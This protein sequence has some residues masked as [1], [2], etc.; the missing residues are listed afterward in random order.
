MS[1]L[2]AELA[3]LAPGASKKIIDGIVAN[4]NFLDEAG[5]TTPLR[6]RHFFARVCVETYGLKRLD[7]NL[8]Y[9]AA[10]LT[11][12]WPKRFPTLASAKPYANNPRKLANK[13]YGGRLG[14]SA[15]NDDGYDH[16]GSGLLQNTGKVN[17]QLVQDETG[18]PV[19]ENPDLLRKFPTALQAATLYWTKHNINKFADKD[20]EVGVCHAVNGGENGLAEQRAYLHTARKVWP[21]GSRPAPAK[22][23]V[24]PI[25]PAKETVQRVQQQL[26]DLNYNPG[27]KDPVKGWDGIPGKLTN[28]AILSFKNDHGLPVNT[29]IDEAFL[30]ALASAPPR[31]MA[32]A[33]ANATGSQV[34]AKVPE[35]NVH[36]WTRLGAYIGLGSTT[37]AG[38]TDYIAPS[39]GYLQTIKDF[40]GDV[41]PWVWFLGVIALCF[42][43]GIAAQYGLNKTKQAFNSGDRR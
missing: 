36:W 22:P 10:R 3:R 4:A 9:S 5:I 42:I 21:E 15:K 40:V 28:G 32:P 17:F 33:R 13:V 2:A 1:N 16:R 24:V 14:N 34:A 19:V 39:V 12:V 41:P 11:V 37:V 43:L 25:P 38:A 18:L 7:E 29:D 6:L 31:E 23:P 26:Y 27:T 8:N 30:T 20:D 35:A